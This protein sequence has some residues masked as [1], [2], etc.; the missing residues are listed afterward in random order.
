MEMNQFQERAK[1]T[2]VYPAWYGIPY[3]T[4]GLT[5]EAGEV[6]EKVKKMIRDGKSLDEAKAGIVDELGDV[7]WYVAALASEL[8][9]SLSNVALRNIEKLAERE[10][11]GTIHGEGDKR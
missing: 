2:A 4:L 1:K 9:V 3:A 6:A 8:G 5:G 10:A 11:K 7:L